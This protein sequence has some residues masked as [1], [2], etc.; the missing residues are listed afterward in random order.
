MTT[1]GGPHT[2][3]REVHIVVP[4]RDEEATL[5]TCLAALS[6]AMDTLRAAPSSAGVRVRLF[7]VLDS[8]RDTSAHIAR[9]AAE[10]DKRIEVVE[11]NLGAVGTARR[12]GV[13]RA[14]ALEASPHGREADASKTWI[15][16]T[17][18]DSTVPPNWL[19][20]QLAFADEGID[21]VLGTVLLDPSTHEPALE[22]KWRHGYESI[23]GH[24]HIHGANLGVRASVY[25]AVGGFLPVPEHEDVELAAAITAVGANVHST[26]VIPVVTSAR[27][28]GRTPGG[29]ASYLN[30]LCGPERPPRENRNTETVRSTR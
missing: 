23:E 13:S 28:L 20:A 27:F 21:L 22:A 6:V 7:L 8:C 12:V 19:V 25:L 18:A 26:A 30:A 10:R 17:D 15:A 4:A 11:A 3:I 14:L 1:G 5:G 16:S 24:P 29:F 2:R 9:R